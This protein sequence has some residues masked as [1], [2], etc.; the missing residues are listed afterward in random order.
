MQK[1]SASIS[2]KKSRKPF[3]T[4]A[5]RPLTFHEINFNAYLLLQFG[6]IFLY[7]RNAFLPENWRDFFAGKWQIR[8]NKQVN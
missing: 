4:A 3:F 8:E 7:L 2:R 5:L 1:K 6:F